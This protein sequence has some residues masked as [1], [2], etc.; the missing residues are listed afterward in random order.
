RDAATDGVLR[1]RADLPGRG[2]PVPPR[3]LARPAPGRTAAG[4]TQSGAKS[5]PA[6]RPADTPAGR[7]RGL[8]G[9]AGSEPPRPEPGPRPAAVAERVIKTNEKLK[10]IGE[11]CVSG[12][13][14]PRTEEGTMR[15]GIATDHGGFGLKEELLARLRAAGHE[16]IDFGAARL[17]PNDD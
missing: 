15:V 4:G 6:R 7:L 10:V 16:V 12:V 3:L 1:G 9:V 8:S 17:D 13:S 2:R 14:G 11:E 5:R